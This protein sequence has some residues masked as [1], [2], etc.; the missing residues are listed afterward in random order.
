[1]E[2][3]SKTKKKKNKRNVTATFLLFLQKSATAILTHQYKC[4]IFFCAIFLQ[5]SKSDCSMPVNGGL[6]RRETE[7]VSTFL[8]RIIVISVDKMR[9]NYENFK[10]RYLLPRPDMNTGHCQHKF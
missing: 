1:M 2:Q 3:I 4:I 8:K 6:R 7:E 5:M 10:R 9:K